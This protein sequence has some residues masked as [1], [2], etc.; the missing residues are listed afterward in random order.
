MRQLSKGTQSCTEIRRIPT[1][2]RP[3]SGNNA[4]V[5][6]SGSNVNSALNDLTQ[7]FPDLRQHL[8]EGDTMRSFVNIYLNQEDVRYLD[9]PETAVGESDTLMII[10]SI[11]GGRQFLIYDFR[12]TID[13]FL[14]IN[15]K[16]PIKNRKWSKR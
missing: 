16:S 7:Q 5:S 4:T 14:A 15:R 13:D 3:Y 10:P 11:A 12:L 6:V 9:G 8:F 2:L 1:P